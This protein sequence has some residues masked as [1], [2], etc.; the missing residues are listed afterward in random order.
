MQQNLKRSGLTV[1]GFRSS[2][3][4][5]VADQTTVPGEI[6]EAALAHAIKTTTEAA[7]RRGD[8]LDR[9]RQLMEQWAKF[10]VSGEA[11]GDKVVPM[12]RQYLP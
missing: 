4:D 10:C 12:G 6:A 3:R 7:Y 8:A 1:H 5:W 11:A 9:R 2:F